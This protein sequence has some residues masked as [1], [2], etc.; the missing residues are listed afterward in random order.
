MKKKKRSWGP[1]SHSSQLV[2]DGAGFR[3]KACLIPVPRIFSR[4]HCTK[5]LITSLPASRLWLCASWLYPTGETGLLGEGHAG[6]FP[7]IQLHWLRSSTKWIH[8][9]S[10]WSR[11]EIKDKKKIQTAQNLHLGASQIEEWWESNESPNED[12]YRLESPRGELLRTS[13]WLG[14]GGPGID[15]NWGGWACKACEA[16]MWRCCPCWWKPTLALG[17]RRMRWKGGSGR[18]KRR[19]NSFG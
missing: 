9:N 13:E 12:S 1:G 11:K 14:T 6:I 3:L 16:M 8:P 15:R 17:H 4:N 18:A 5:L 19:R 10:P 2:S 7:P